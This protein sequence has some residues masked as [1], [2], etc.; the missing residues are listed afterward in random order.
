MLRASGIREPSRITARAPWWAIRISAS[1][2]RLAQYMNSIPRR[3]F[4]KH[5]AAAGCLSG[6]LAA[7]PG[8]IAIVTGAP[9]GIS[10]SE[11]V[12]W[13][14]VELR[15]AVEEKGD[16]CV[17]VSSP[18]EAGDFQAAV[19]VALATGSPAESFRLAPEKISGKR[20]VR[21][22]AS[23]H[24]GL[25]YAISELADRVRHATNPVAALTLAAPLEEQPANR[26]RSINRAFL[27]DVE[28]KS[29]FRS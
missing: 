16:S 11:P 20:A 29:W 9:S 25:V 8:R 10:S 5:A 14:A 28:D 24:R 6:R 23:D 21:A 1:A 13:A 3:N 4:L 15:R 12:R 18:G 2:L 22:S 26:V 27:S 19:M 7:A 17:I